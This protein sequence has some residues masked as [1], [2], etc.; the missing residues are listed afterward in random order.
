MRKETSYVS[1]L[2]IAPVPGICPMSRLISTAMVLL[3]ILLC[4]VQM[5]VA[6]SVVGSKNVPIQTA[7]SELFQFSPPKGDGPVVVRARF[8]LQ[9]VNMIDDRSETFEFTGVLTLTW[10]DPRQAFDPAVAGVNEKI[11]TGDYQ[12]N[13]ISPGWYPQGGPRQRIRLVPEERCPLA[14]KA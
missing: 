13:E 10:R 5:A 11:F 9:D 6:D 12:V 14:S 3:A 2:L 7:S 1:A 4:S 8:E